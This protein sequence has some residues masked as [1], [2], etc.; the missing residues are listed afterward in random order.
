LLTV[1][2]A[3]TDGGKYRSISD[4]LAGLKKPWATIRVLDAAT[5]RETVVLDQQE[6]HE[7]LR[8][9]APKRASLTPPSAS[10]QVLLVGSV[11]RVRVRGFRFRQEAVGQP[12]LR[13]LVLV[14]G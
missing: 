1:S 2:R 11:A 3:A 9:E 8:L 10:D 14:K 6:L 7:G 4:A 12:P 13:Y 5:Y